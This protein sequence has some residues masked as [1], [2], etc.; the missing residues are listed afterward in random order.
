MAKIKKTKAFQGLARPRV[1]VEDT[2]TNSFY[3]QLRE[4][5]EILHAGKN[6]FLIAGTE[7]LNPN[8]E[9][10]VEIIDS[11]GDTVFNQPIKNYAEGLSRVVS[12]EIYDDTPPGPA[13]M[14]IL[15][16]LRATRDGTPIPPQFQGVYNVR[17]Q[18]RLTLDPL[19]VNDSKIRLY[20]TPLLTVK[21]ILSPYR[22]ATTGS[23]NTVLGTGSAVGDTLIR[24]VSTVNPSPNI[25]TVHTA[26]TPLSR[27]MEG[28]SFTASLVL[29]EF[30]GTYTTSI[31]SVLN[32]STMQVDPAL[33]NYS[34]TL[35]L[36][37]V[38]DNFTISFK[39]TTQ[40]S[41]TTLTRSF[42]DVQIAKLRTFSGEVN[43]ARLYIKSL[44]QEGEFQPMADQLLQSAIITQTQSAVLGP[45]VPMGDITSQQVINEFWVGGFINQGAP[46]YT[47]TASVTISR[48][49]SHL[50]DSMYIANASQLLATGSATASYFIGTS[51]S[52]P[53]FSQL[54]Y[55]FSTDVLCVKSNDA[56]DAKMEVYL[57]GSAFPSISPFGVKLAT[58]ESPAGQIKMLKRDNETNFIPNEDGSGSLN[59][60]IYG[61]Q[62][63]MS[64]TSV[65]SAFATGFNPDIA[66]FIIP[67]LN[68]RFEHLQ[69]KAQV[70]DPNN[71][72]F[73]QEIL[74]DSVFFDG[75]NLL[76]R[77]TDHRIEGKLTVSPSGS[78]VT[79]SSDGF[80]GEDGSP[81]SGSAIYM[82]QGRFFH[83]GTAF[84]IA[85]FPNNNPIISLGDKLKG[86]I[87]PNTNE[88]VL[89]IQGT[90]LVGSGSSLTDLLSLL[91]H[92]I[93]DTYFHRLR[94]TDLDFWDIQ[95]KKAIHAANIQSDTAANFAQSQQVARMGRYTRG[96]IPRTV[97]PE[98]P[99]IIQGATGAIDPLNQ[100]T[101][102]A[103]LS[104]SGTINVPSGVM[105][106]N[107][108]LYG[109]IRLDL[110]E[111]VMGAGSA[112]KVQF[113]LIVDSSWVGY[114]SGSGVG[115][116]DIVNLD[117]TRVRQTVA[118]DKQFFIATTG[119]FSPDP[120][121]SYPIHVPQNRPVGYN[122]LYVVV[123]LDITTTAEVV[124]GSG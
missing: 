67:V 109:N 108:T 85:A 95:G 90:I 19:R 86:Y 106:W 89:L 34:G 13:L 28:G 25:Y 122:T 22:K 20:D 104:L 50:I 68:R 98:S 124:S 88:F 21:E 53:F 55:V 8:T 120:F 80:F 70:F 66:E 115:S 47:P 105:I 94:G 97:P 4:S 14:T 64:N 72:I 113:E 103:S 62:W 71:N 117:G 75:G 59:F 99:L 78:G 87:D 44:D 31:V 100:T 23:M 40:F 84:L 30:T 52:L 76:L 93:T 18:K 81:Q 1:F 35:F 15:G 43:R 112:Y 37:F 110:A 83:S 63:Y 57:T 46:V 38:S 45:A 26:N 96:T 79:I 48:D 58:F 54:E 3:F 74:S 29:P 123:E 116:T 33:E 73:P 111:L 39:D 61:G 56:F 9:V 119:S 49:T 82:G 60:V 32:D 102:H 11:N 69:F 51:G 42:A 6:A 16:E 92:E 24:I 107:E 36:P 5:D 41:S 114:L 12:I 2:D 118:T 77:G 91:S 101:T 17:F 7:F 121:I 65:I 27:S 10:L